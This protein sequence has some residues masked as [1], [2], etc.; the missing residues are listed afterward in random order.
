[1]LIIMADDDDVDDLATFAG[2]N[3]ASMGLPG[4]SRCGFSITTMV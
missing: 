2:R 1:M 3:G 4:V